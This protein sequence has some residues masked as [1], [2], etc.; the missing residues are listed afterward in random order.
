MTKNNI[1]IITCFQNK[2]LFRITR[3]CNL[4]ANI[5]IYSFDGRGGV[6]GLKFLNYIGERSYY[7]RKYEV[8]VFLDEDFI[9]VDNITFAEYLDC[10]INSQFTFCGV[11]DGGET[12]MRDYSPIIPN[13]FCLFMKTKGDQTRS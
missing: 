8:L 9:I 3:K 4:C 13:T 12:P 7:F 1:A 10:F 5:P 6:Y 11:R 2:D